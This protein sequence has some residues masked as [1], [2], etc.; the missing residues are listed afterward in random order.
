MWNLS[1]DGGD[2]KLLY[3][4][5]GTPVHIQI[6]NAVSLLAIGSG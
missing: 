3:L 4:D 5:L 1:P 2:Q 6:E